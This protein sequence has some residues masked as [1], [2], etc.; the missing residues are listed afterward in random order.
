MSH[1]LGTPPT[2]WAPVAVF[3]YNRPDKLAAMIT[4]LRACRGFSETP[5]TIFVDG[6]KS[7]GDVKSVEAVRAF[8]HALG[9]PNV[10]S[11]F[12]DANRGL[13]RSIYA[14][15]SELIV[16]H[17]NVIVL[18]D[19]LLLS[20][21]ALDYFNEGLHRYRSDDRVWSIAGYAYDAPVLRDLATTFALPFA[22]PWGWATWARAWEQFQLDNRPASHQLDAQSFKSAFDMNG[23]YPF[24]ALLR[25]SIEGRVDSWFI[26]WYYTVF[27]NGG[28]S[29]FPSRRVVDNF[30]HSAGSHGGA[31]N[32]YDRL[33]T[34]PEL[35]NEGPQFREGCGVDYAALDALRACHELRVQRLIARAGQAKRALR[36]KGK[37]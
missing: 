14:G 8:V 1:T 3:A 30:G 2:D 24:T 36:S 25:N 10:S 37:R 7:R 5:V 22:H 15:V 20:P 9:L 21:G 13:R 31:L 16:K 19:D 17:G 29:I 35:L 23:L 34:R 11:S 4:S 32:P 33:V 27:E 6:P 18:E 12:Q 26:H 28:V